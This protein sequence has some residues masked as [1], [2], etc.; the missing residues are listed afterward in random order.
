MSCSKKR[1]EY[2]EEVGRNPLNYDTWFDFVRLEEQGGD[3]D[4]IREVY[5]RAVAQ[6]PP[7]PE[8]RLWQRYIYLW[9]NYALYEELEAGDLGRAREVYRACLRVVPHK[10]FTFGKVWIMAAQLEVRARDLQAARKTFGMAIGMCPKAKVFEAYIDMEIQLGNVDNCR[11]L[12]DKYL[13]WD[14]T[15]VAAWCRYAELEADLG[16]SERARALYEVAIAQV[17]MRLQRARPEPALQQ[18]EDRVARASRVRQ[19][20]AKGTAPP[21]PS[22][23]SKTHCGL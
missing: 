17:S 23:V 9:I 8:K 22:C 3:R 10:V 21:K 16:E 5:E 4:R 12:Y 18:T 20:H 7:V 2:E 15:R 19:R 13:V 6:L 11:K 14:P 1:M